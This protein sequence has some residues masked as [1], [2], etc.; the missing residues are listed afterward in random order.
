MCMTAQTCVLLLQRDEGKLLSPK[1][2]NT[3]EG[4]EHYPETTRGMSATKWLHN[5]TEHARKGESQPPPPPPTL[6]PQLKE[7]GA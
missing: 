1:V 2:F 5:T 4:S 7:K 3:I 6:T